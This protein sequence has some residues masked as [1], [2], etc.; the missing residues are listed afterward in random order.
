MRLPLKFGVGPG[1]T[2]E[3]HR[4]RV[5]MDRLGGR[6]EPQDYG[7]VQ[8]LLPSTH[9]SPSRS[10]WFLLCAQAVVQL[11]SLCWLKCWYLENNA[12]ENLVAKLIANTHEPV[13]TTRITS[14]QVRSMSATRVRRVLCLS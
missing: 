7:G 6:R 3:R 8:G 14:K 13:G 11:R 5:F 2:Q 10:D 1:S 4:N 12:G 9:R